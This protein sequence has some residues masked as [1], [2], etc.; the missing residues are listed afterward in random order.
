MN[1]DFPKLKKNFLDNGFFICK[2]VFKK[3][4]IQLFLIFRLEN[5]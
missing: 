4:D 5:I 1:L 2:D 3:N